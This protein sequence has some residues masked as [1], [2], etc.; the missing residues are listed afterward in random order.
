MW[1]MSLS[2]FESG[3]ASSGDFAIDTATA[4]TCLFVPEQ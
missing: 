2:F 1:T 3:R 4:F